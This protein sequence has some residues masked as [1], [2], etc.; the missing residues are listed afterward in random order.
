MDRQRGRHIDI[1]VLISFLYVK[2][3]VYDTS[4]SA[5]LHDLMPLDGKHT[6]KRRRHKRA[7]KKCDPAVGTYKVTTIRV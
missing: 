1:L 4:K 6:A 7:A 2:I 3:G 5:W